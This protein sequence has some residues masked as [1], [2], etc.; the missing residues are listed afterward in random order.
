MFKYNKED[1]LKDTI[2]IIKYRYEKAALN[3]FSLAAKI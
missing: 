2:N 1:L 3:V